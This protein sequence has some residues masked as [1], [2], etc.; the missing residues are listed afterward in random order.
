MSEVRVSTGVE[1]LDEVLAGG[2]LP[3]RTYLLSGPPG[4]GKTTLGWHYLVAGIQAGEPVLYISFAE[5]EAELRANAARSGFDAAAVEVLDLS[6]AAEL[7]AKSET[8]DIFSARE[9]E[10]EPTTARIIETI[11]RVGPRR[12]FVDSMTHLRHL[13]TDAYQFRRQALSFLRFVSELG[14]VVVT[15]ESTPETPDDDLRFITDGVI[16]IGVGARGRELSVSKFRGSDYRAG[17]HA[18]TLSDSGAAV[19]PRLIPESHRRPFVPEPLSS[20]LPLLDTLLHGGIERGTVTLISG[21]TGVGKTTLGMQ[22]LVE[23]AT[24]GER[25]ALYTFDERADTVIGRC[26][27]VGIPVRKMIDGGA[28]SVIELE[29]LRFGPDEFANIVRRDVEDRGTRIVMI[30]SVSGY[31]MSVSDGLAERIHA[32]GRYLQNIGVTV[33]LVDELHEVTS[34][35]VTEVGISYLADNVIFLRYLERVIDGTIELRKGIGVLKKRLSDFEKGVREFTITRNGVH[36][37]EPLR[38]NSILAE[39]PVD[40]PV[41]T[42]A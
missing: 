32:L 2:L 16:E 40:E 14:S 26:H 5:P 30:D 11:Q 38:L 23:A 41:H 36:I 22:F 15:S 25:S 19:F 21:P 4:S 28:L 29:A 20:G 27:A 24:R 42:N 6:P 31:R 10:T 8:Y 17:R 18:L 33:I 12:V 34:F 39:L 1:G 35:R 9:V 13:S 3:G 37:G 7:F